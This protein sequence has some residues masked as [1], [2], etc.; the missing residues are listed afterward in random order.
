MKK[1]DKQTTTTTTQCTAESRYWDKY[2]L[3]PNQFRLA[4]CFQY[5]TFYSFSFPLHAPSTAQRLHQ[6]ATQ[7]EMGA[8]T[9]S[10]SHTSALSRRHYY[11]SFFVLTFQSLQ[12]GICTLFL[13]EFNLTKWG[14]DFCSISDHQPCT[15]D[16]TGSKKKSFFSLLLFFLLLHASINCDPLPQVFSCALYTQLLTAHSIPE[17]IVRFLYPLFC[18]LFCSLSIFVY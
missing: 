12:K 16:G 10:S 5:L 18:I 13:Y 17:W 7:G 8:N 3:T 4:A 1:C 6:V 15:D 2:S 11:F 14:F 9:S